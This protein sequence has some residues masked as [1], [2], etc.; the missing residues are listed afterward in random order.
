M[1][2]RGILRQLLACYCHTGPTALQFTYGPH[3][4]PALSDTS[5]RLHFNASHSSNVVAFAF[6]RVGEIGVDIELIRHAMP[7]QHEIAEKHFS[8]GEFNQ[9][10][11]LL[12]TERTEAFFR[13]WTRK[14]AFLKARG[15]GVFGGLNTFE[16]SIEEDDARLL[17]VHGES[18]SHG[19]WMAPLHGIQAHAGA[20]AVRSG[21]SSLSCWRVTPDIFRR[22]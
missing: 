2:T 11:S 14:E 19:W 16:V 9:L 8:P 18:D 17:R 6:T 12:E 13:C 22:N 5:L 1:L 7:R 20:V 4:K 21:E 3:G 15:D 10:Q